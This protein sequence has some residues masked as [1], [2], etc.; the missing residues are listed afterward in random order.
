MNP[1]RQQETKAVDDAEFTALSEKIA[2][3]FVEVYAAY[4]EK[5]PKSFVLVSMTGALAACATE[6]GA[7]RGKIVAAINAAFDDIGAGESTS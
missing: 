7:E 6:A 2:H 5:V 1:C 4:C 3:S